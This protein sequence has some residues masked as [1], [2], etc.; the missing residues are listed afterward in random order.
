MINVQKP[1]PF[2]LTSTNHGVM[3][4]NRNDYFMINQESGYGVGFQI[5]NTSSFDQ[6]EIDF[7]LALI[8]RRKVNFGEGVIAIDCGANIGV[9]TVE[10]SRLMTSWGEVIAFEAQEKI[11]Y[12]LAG[13]VILNN[14]LN[15]TVKNAALGASCGFIE[16]P[17]PNYLIPSSY[18]SFELQ[19]KKNNEYIGQE[20]NYKKTKKIPLVTIDSLSLTRLDFMKI[21]VEGMEED[22]LEGSKDTIL[23]FKPIMIIEIIKSNKD[24]LLSFLESMSYFIYPLGINLLAI[25]KEDP[26]NSSIKIDSNGIRLD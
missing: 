10:W 18:G 6:Q 23:K 21:D 12:A 19:K 5:L 20:I 9:H 22:V 11:F 1:I 13:N 17:E 25:H 15:V 2:V 14:C 8:Y 16:I 3:I 4:V 7:A 24:K 26:I